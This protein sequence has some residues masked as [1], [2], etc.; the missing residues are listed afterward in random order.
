MG[1]SRRLRVGSVGLRPRRRHIHQ[2]GYQRR[3][4]RPRRHPCGRRLLHDGLEFQPGAGAADTLLAR[5][6]ELGDR[7]QRPRATRAR[8]LLRHSTPR[9][10]SVGPLHTPPQ[11]GILHLLG[12]PRLRSIY[13]EDRRPS[14]ALVGADSGVGRERNHRP[15]AALGRRR[16]SI[17]GER[18]GCQPRR[19]Q[20]HHHHDG[21]APRRHR[22]ARHPDDSLRRQ[23]RG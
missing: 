16:K 21:D 13:G 8:G 23:R 2:P 11:R 19:P 18:L 10:R 3:L 12:R 20:R 7:Q 4:Q 5:P 14:G 15:G 17:S 9:Q 6:V 1:H 22:N